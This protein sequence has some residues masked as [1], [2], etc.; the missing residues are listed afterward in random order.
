[1]TDGRAGAPGAPELRLPELDVAPLTVR[2]DHPPATRSGATSGSAE[3]RRRVI[4]RLGDR[5][6]SIDGH[7]AKAVR[8]VEMVTPVPRTP[9]YVLGV[10]AV[11]DRIL[12]LVSLAGPIGA[13][14]VAGPPWIGLVVRAAGFDVVLAVDEVIDWQPVDPDQPTT[15]PNLDLARLLR[16]LRPSP[17]DRSPIR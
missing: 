15:V 8:R 17:R 7:H 6:V 14:P 12:P 16:D 4:L 3:R 2:W 1:M 11:R 13:P 9:P 5:R 10:A